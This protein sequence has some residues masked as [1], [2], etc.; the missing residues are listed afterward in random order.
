MPIENQIE[1]PQSFMALYTEPGR[2][3]PNAPQEVILARYEHCEDMANLLTE[4]ASAIAFRETLSETEI[5]L[6]CHQ[7]L[8]APTSGFSDQE[9]LWVT[10]RLAELLGWEF[11]GPG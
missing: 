7:G 5:L 6:R 1:P 2:H 9:A 3:T 10:R 11:S 4:H 8:L